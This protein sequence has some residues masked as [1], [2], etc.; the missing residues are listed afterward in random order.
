MS[1]EGSATTPV[2]FTAFLLEC[3]QHHG[4]EGV[5]A[6][7]GMEGHLRTQPSQGDGHIQRH[8]ARAHHRVPGVHFLIRFGHPGDRK[9]QVDTGVTHHVDHGSCNSTRKR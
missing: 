5:P 3:L 7:P 8:P 4:T 9:D 6:D 2:V 1:I